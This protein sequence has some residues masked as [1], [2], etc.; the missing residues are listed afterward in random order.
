MP[1]YYRT[2]P[3]QGGGLP[4]ELAGYI[5]TGPGA[6][7]HDGIV[8]GFRVLGITPPMRFDPPAAGWTP[9]AGSPGWDVVSAGPF[10][11]L[12]HFRQ[13]TAWKMAQ[14]RV[15]GSLWA[16]PHVLCPDGSRAF[17]VAYGGPDFA[18]QLTPEQG[19][20]QRL[21]IEI[22]TAIQA[23]T[24]PE[25]SIQARWAA[26]L[27]PLAYHLTEGSLAVLGMPEELIDQTLR[28]TAGL[29]EQRA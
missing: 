28:V 11:Q 12:A 13:Q 14:V 7:L 26:R 19:R 17:K 24:L 27:L 1:L 16:I 10:D 23:D 21:A 25:V 20:A 6:D 2:T 4:P 5:S 29:Y 8:G 15:Q 9:L 3:G 18:P 22:R